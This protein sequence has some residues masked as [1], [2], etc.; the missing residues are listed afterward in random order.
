M[1]H[2]ICHISISVEN[3]VRKYVEL[4]S[5][6][7]AKIHLNDEIISVSSDTIFVRQK[8]EPSLWRHLF[9]FYKRYW[10][11]VSVIFWNWG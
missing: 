4:Y 2:M 11:S 3:N 7:P 9:D 1:Q 5:N 10:T 8:Y 6:S